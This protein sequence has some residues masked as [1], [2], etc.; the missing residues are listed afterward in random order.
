MITSSGF[1]NYSMLGIV[2][3]LEYVAKMFERWE[4][5]SI[6]GNI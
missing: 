4:I 5:V 6:A 1:S 2:I 3:N